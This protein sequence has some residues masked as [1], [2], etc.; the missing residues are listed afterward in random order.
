MDSDFTNFHAGCY[1]PVPLEMAICC[2]DA[3]PMQYR[4]DPTRPHS[5]LCQYE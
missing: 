2:E 4:S 5:P 1:G 3:L